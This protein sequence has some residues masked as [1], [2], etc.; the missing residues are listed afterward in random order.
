M[1]YQADIKSELAGAQAEPL[2]PIEIKLITWSL[3]TGI[4][5]LVVL[6]L[7]GRFIFPA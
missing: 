7:A 3:G 2:L 5:L 6:G 1:A 4:V